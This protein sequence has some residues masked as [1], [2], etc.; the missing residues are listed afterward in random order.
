MKFFRPSTNNTKEM[1]LT[2]PMHWFSQGQW[3]SNLWMQLL[4]V[5]QCDARGGRYNKQVSQYLTL[6]VWPLITTSLVLGSFT[7]GFTSAIHSMDGKELNEAL[8][9][10]GGFVFLGIIPGF[11]EDVMKRKI[12]SCTGT[13]VKPSSST[14]LLE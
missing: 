5:E 3:W 1:V 12:K 11:L 8:S 9:E 6:T 10:M 2:A 7:S 13:Q 4:Q 14:T